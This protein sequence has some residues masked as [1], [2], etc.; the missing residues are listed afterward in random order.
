MVGPAR[1]DET[2]IRLASL[3]AM[4]LAMGQI[5]NQGKIPDIILVDG[6]DVFKLPDGAP[7]VPVEAFIKGDGR[8]LAIAAASIVAKVYR[9]ALM[10]EYH[11]IWPEYGFDKHAGYPTK[12]HK[13]ALVEHGPC[14]IHRRSFRGVLT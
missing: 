3:E 11:S 10:K 5:L 2:N 7:T 4:G 12:A 9:D 14:E 13:Q 6:R 1:I 8:S